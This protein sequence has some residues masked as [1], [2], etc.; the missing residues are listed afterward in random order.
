MFSMVDI[1]QQRQIKKKFVQKRENVEL[2]KR[3]RLLLVEIGK[4]LIQ[5]VAKLLMLHQRLIM[6]LI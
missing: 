2:K 5:L 6:I 3:V 4:R 1:Y